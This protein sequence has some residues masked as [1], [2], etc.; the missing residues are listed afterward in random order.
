MRRQASP[1]PPLPPPLPLPF[2]P[3]PPLPPLPPLPSP[4]SPPSPSLP[5]PLTPPFSPPPP[6]PLATPLPSA[7]SD[8][9][10]PSW[11][12]CR[13]TP[14]SSLCS[15]APPRAIIGMDRPAPLAQQQP[16]AACNPILVERLDDQQPAAAPAFAA[17][18]AGKPAF[19][20]HTLADGQQGVN[21]DRAAAIERSPLGKAKARSQVAA[22]LTRAL[23]SGRVRRRI[24][25][26]A[27][28]RQLD[29]VDRKQGGRNDAAMRARCPRQPRRTGTPD[30]RQRLRQTA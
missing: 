9:V 26:T 30:S 1:P 17:A 11:D 15:P 6:D 24:E 20:A 25:R 22:D 2:P 27:S 16:L 29:R 14:P 21:F 12:P 28:R 19:R 4:L 8:L 7:P 23:A 3:P 13:R 5:P 18:H 10:S